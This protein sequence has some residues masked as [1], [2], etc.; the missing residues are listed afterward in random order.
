MKAKKDTKSTI[1]NTITKLTSFSRHIHT[2]MYVDGSKDKILVYVNKYF[3]SLDTEIT[4]STPNSSPEKLVEGST[5]SAETW[6]RV[7]LSWITWNK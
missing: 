3:E 1:I 5:R 7:L 4:V 6:E 2:Q